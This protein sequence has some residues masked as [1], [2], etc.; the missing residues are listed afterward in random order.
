[1]K[2]HWGHHPIIS[3]PPINIYGLP[4]WLCGKESAC[5]AGA[6]GSVPGSGGSPGEGNGYPLQYSCLEN[7]IDRGAWW[8]TVHGVTVGHD[9]VTNTFTFTWRIVSQQQKQNQHTFRKYPDPQI[10][11]WIFTKKIKGTQYILLS[12]G[13]ILPRSGVPKLRQKQSFNKNSQESIPSFQ[14]SFIPKPMCMAMQV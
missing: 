6:L 2:I 10:T 12:I 9:W 4:W 3:A 14:F 8:A 13:I 5:N 11:L 7:P 1:M